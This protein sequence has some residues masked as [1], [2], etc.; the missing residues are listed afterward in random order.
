MIVGP[1]SGL[2]S[3]KSAGLR[4]AFCIAKNTAFRS[5]LLS[6]T[7]GSSVPD[8]NGLRRCF[9]LDF[10]YGR[11]VGHQL[12]DRPVYKPNLDNTIRF[13]SYDPA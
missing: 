7:V 3:V 8:S 12:T 2:L 1:C 4:P 9:V 6:L 10:V 11:V 5:L 13:N